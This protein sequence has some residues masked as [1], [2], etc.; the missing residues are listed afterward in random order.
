M[1]SHNSVGL[2]FFLSFGSW[3]RIFV[4]QWCWFLFFIY[5]FGTSFSFWLDA[6]GKVVTF[7]SGCT[8]LEATTTWSHYESIS[9][10]KL[11]LE[12]LLGLTDQKENVAALE[13]DGSPLVYIGDQALQDVFELT[14]SGVPAG[15]LLNPIQRRYASGVTRHFLETNLVVPSAESSSGNTV[16]DVVVQQ[17]TEVATGRRRRQRRRRRMLRGSADY[18]EDD[19]D[20]ELYDSER[21]MD[22]VHFS[23]KDMD[24]HHPRN[25]QDSTAS[26]ST[27]SVVYSVGDPNK[28]NDFSKSIKTLFSKQQRVYTS[29]LKLEQLRPGEIN[30]GANLGAIFQGLIGVQMSGYIPPNVTDTN[31]D[32]SDEDE[33]DNSKLWIL[34]WS[35]VLAVSVVWLTYR[36][37]KDY[38]LVAEEAFIHKREKLSERK[39]RLEEEREV[40]REKRRLKKEMRKEREREKRER[41]RS[42]VGGGGVGRSMRWGRSE[43]GGGGGGGVGLSM[44]WGRGK[45]KNNK[46]L[47]GDISKEEYGHK[48]EAAQAVERGELGSESGPP[49]AAFDNI[50]RPNSFGGGSE[51]VDP[52]RPA[53]RRPSFDSGPRMVERRPSL[54]SGPRNRAGEGGRGIKAS[55]SMDM[56]PRDFGFAPKRVSQIE[57]LD[58]ATSLPKGGKKPDHLKY[59]AGSS[60]SVQSGPRNRAGEGGRGIKSSNSMSSQPRSMD[61]LQARRGGTP[62]RNGSNASN[63]GRNTIGDSGH[64]SKT[65]NSI[66]GSNHS[67]GSGPKNMAGQSRGMQASRSMPMQKRSV[68]GGGGSIPGLDLAGARSGLPPRKPTNAPSRNTAGANGRGIGAS[69]S[70]GSSMAAMAAAANN[71]PSPEPLKRGVKPGS[72]KPP[73]SPHNVTKTT[74][75]KRAMADGSLPKAPADSPS[76]K[77]KKK[78]TPASPDGSPV[79][80]KKKKK[81]PSDPDSPVKAKKPSSKKKKKAAEG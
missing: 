68:S 7:Q 80:K 58:L 60:H 56:A 34:I 14:L 12:V 31:D 13:Q 62:R 53:E 17:Q 66:Q 28:A 18:E 81:T 40:R 24:H 69:K 4:V 44:R 73:L 71:L 2:I 15:T 39:A 21:N 78:K 22:D 29:A 16:Y 25:L 11:T 3:F 47:G 77:K 67:G 45:N 76:V 9:T 32:A 57:G 42:E 79:V 5:F 41:R 72:N 65:S 50:K 75:P 52:P 55:R 35:S 43:G 70:A 61:D 49:P 10:K 30:Q 37:C 59:G 74:K 48:S 20:M 6:C 19:E 63:S 33:T 1:T 27:L 51:A 23:N 36:V 8:L 26:L 46:P 54:D 64:S 38:F